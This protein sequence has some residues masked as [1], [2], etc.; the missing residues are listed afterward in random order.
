MKKIVS[1]VSLM[2]VIM[3]SYLFF[4]KQDTQKDEKI[5]SPTVIDKENIDIKNTLEI[6]VDSSPLFYKETILTKPQIL[7][8]ENKIEQ[9][10]AYFEYRK[11][12]NKRE[13]QRIKQYLAYK[14]KMEQIY[15]GGVKSELSHIKQK[16]EMIYKKQYQS[17]SHY[18][19][20]QKKMRKEAFFRH[21]KEMMNRRK[22]IESLQR[23]QR[24]QKYKGE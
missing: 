16:K 18:L 8:K 19:M 23:M 14:T 11:E 9:Q 24:L 22:E 2:A 15:K 21:K 10:K 3:M 12:Q 5:A 1:L 17:S 6:R 4:G 13:H 7:V 20:S